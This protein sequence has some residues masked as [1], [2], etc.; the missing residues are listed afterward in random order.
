MASARYRVVEGI[1][2]IVETAC[3]R[4]PTLMVLEDLHWADESTLVTFRSMAHELSHVPLLLVGS[5]RPSPRSAELDQLVDESLLSDARL[6]R[7]DSSLPAMS[8]P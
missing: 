2:D 3:A 1:I 6:V 7:L 4:A 5:M 8:T